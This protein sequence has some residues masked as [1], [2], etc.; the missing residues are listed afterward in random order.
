MGYSISGLE[1][2][3]IIVFHGKRRIRFSKTS[4]WFTRRYS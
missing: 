4:N 3:D 2:F 1:R